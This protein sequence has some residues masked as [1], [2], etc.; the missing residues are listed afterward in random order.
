MNEEFNEVLVSLNTIKEDLEIPKNI[1]L[2]ICN[3]ISCLDE[4]KEFCLKA[5]QII[6]DLEEITID[7]N[8]PPD[9]RIEIMN[10]V[11]ILGKFN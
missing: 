6:E 10:L 5:S 3:T 8:I 2:K 9:V 7:P 1:R 11:S 4:D